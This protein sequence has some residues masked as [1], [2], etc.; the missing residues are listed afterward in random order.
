M[1][2]NSEIQKLVTNYIKSRDAL[3][4]AGI[5]RTDRNLQGD[6]AEWIVAKKLNLTLS[7]STIQKGYDATDDEGKTYQVKSRM[8]YSVDQQTSFDFQSLDHKF[9]FLIAVFFNKDLD[10]IKIIK[11]PY[12][13]VLENAIKNKK[14]Y[15]FRWYKGMSGNAYIEDISLI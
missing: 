5:L 3:K 15:R 9:D 13:A 12:E 4:A 10:L 11:V 2:S 14:N 8:V 7:E 6:Y 1:V